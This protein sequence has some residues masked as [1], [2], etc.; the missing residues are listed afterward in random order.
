MEHQNQQTIKSVLR[1]SL[2][3]LKI[4][5]KA[6][7]DDAIA[8]YFRLL[9]QKNEFI[10]LISPKQDIRDKVIIH[11]VDSLTPLL[12]SE[13]PQT[14]QAMDF[15]SGG[16]LP[17]I[18]LSIARPGWHYTLIESTG[19]KTSFLSEVQ[20][21]LSLDNITVINSFLESGKNSE[22]RFYTLI[23]ARGVSD[24][25]K[26]LS[27]S[28]PRLSKG[29]FFI[30]FKGPQGDQELKD[31]HSELKKRKMALCERLDFT[32]PFLEAERR[33]FIFQKS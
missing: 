1:E 23:T 12:W 27:F 29:G 5:I 14:A 28:G 20:S 7:S 9:L 26:L 8:A 31:S 11:L 17:A 18:P 15:G 25:K 30:A 32:L 4:E 6:G 19:K 2:H 16:G 10:N 33:L 13:L 3:T 22:N 24:L 21:R